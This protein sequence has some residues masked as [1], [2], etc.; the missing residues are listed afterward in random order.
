MKS[1]NSHATCSDFSGGQTLQDRHWKKHPEWCL[2]VVNA[3]LPEPVYLI[4]VANITRLSTPRLGQGK[5][6]LS[7][8][9]KC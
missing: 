6:T 7:G 3:R 8:G 4:L 2:Q 9:K 5:K 1:N